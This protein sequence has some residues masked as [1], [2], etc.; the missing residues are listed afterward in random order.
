[1]FTEKTLKL[2]E[3]IKSDGLKKVA[4]KTLYVLYN[5]GSYAFVSV[6]LY[7]GLTFDECVYLHSEKIDSYYNKYTKEW[8]KLSI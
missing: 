5:F 1:M 8:M 3:R 4:E 7:N 6:S 2:C